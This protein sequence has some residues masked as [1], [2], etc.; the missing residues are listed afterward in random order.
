M[1]FID[2]IVSVSGKFYFSTIPFSWI[3]KIQLVLTISARRLFC[4]NVI[5]IFFSRLIGYHN[6]FHDNIIIFWKKSIWSIYNN[7]KIYKIKNRSFTINWHFL[8]LLS[9]SCQFKC[10]TIFHFS[11][12][13]YLQTCYMI[14]DSPESQVTYSVTI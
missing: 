7:P 3:K 5:K 8:T 9:I 10:F 4:V 12:W 13:R 1:D 6:H 2:I 14:Q 11:T